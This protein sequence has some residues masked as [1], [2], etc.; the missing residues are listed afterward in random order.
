[1]DLAGWERESHADA[2][3]LDSNDAAVAK[4]VELAKKHNIKAKAY[5]VEITDVGKVQST[6]EE[7]VRDF[8]RL[9]VL[10]ANAGMAISKPILETTIEE[11][12]QQMAVNGECRKDE[13][14][15]GRDG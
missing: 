3:P 1:V 9:D 11:Y 10:V 2:L 8:G 7:V 4:G 12:R 13:H 5:Q 6:I 14:E 15:S